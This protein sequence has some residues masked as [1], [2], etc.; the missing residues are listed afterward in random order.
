MAKRPTGSNPTTTP[1][2]RPVE[3]GRSSRKA[4]QAEAE[5]KRRRTRTAATSAIAAV[6]VVVVAMIA[7]AALNNSSRTAKRSGGAGN[8]ATLVQHVPTSALDAAGAG[9]VLP[10]ALPAGTQPLEQNGKPEVLYIGAEYCP[11]CAAERWPLIVALSRFGTFQKLGGTESSASDVYPRTQT[12]TF[13]GATY[14][15]DVLAFTPVETATNQPAPG[16]GY[17]SLEQPTAAEAALYGRYD[18][19]PY[20]TQANA[21]PFLMIGNKYVSIGTTYDPLVLQGLSRDEIATALSDPSSPVA[22]AVNGAANTLTAAI[23]QATGGK[24]SSVCADP[25]IAKIAQTL[26]H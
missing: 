3:P 25:T 4:R 2:K 19:P 14:S 18:Q 26:P 24:P 1:K 15:S 7:I 12:F 21:I 20:T 13:H 11:Y 9:S 5:R 16:G 22:R 17:T 6:V 8:A 23:C 10:Q